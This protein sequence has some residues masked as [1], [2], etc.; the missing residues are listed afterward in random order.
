METPQIDGNQ[1]DQEKSDK[2][3]IGRGFR[4]ALKTPKN[5]PY[6]LELDRNFDCVGLEFDEKRNRLYIG[7]VNQ[8]NKTFV[9]VDPKGLR[10]MVHQDKSGQRLSEWKRYIIPGE[11]SLAKTVDLLTKKYTP[12]KQIFEHYDFSSVKK[13]LT[14]F[15][16]PEPHTTLSDIVSITRNTEKE[17]KLLALKHRK[18]EIAGALLANGLWQKRGFFD[19]KKTA[20]KNFWQIIPVQELIVGDK[21]DLKRW[22]EDA[23]I[24]SAKELPEIINYGLESH[25]NGLESYRNDYAI[26]LKMKRL[27]ENHGHLTEEEY[28]EKKKSYRMRGIVEKNALLKPIRD[29]IK[30]G[31]LPEYPWEI[32]NWDKIPF[33]PLK[34]ALLYG[35]H[36]MPEWEA[37]IKSGAPQIEGLIDALQNGFVADQNIYD[38]E[39]APNIEQKNTFFRPF[40]KEIEDK[41]RKSLVLFTKGKILDGQNV[42]TDRERAI[43][44]K[45]NR[46][47]SLW[48]EK[49]STIGDVKK[50][51]LIDIFEGKRENQ[52]IVPDFACIDGWEWDKNGTSFLA[53]ETIKE[54]KKKYDTELYK[55]NN[56]SDSIENK[57]LLKKYL[58]NLKD[59]EEHNINL[60]KCIAVK[61][62]NGSQK[63]IILENS[64]R[65]KDW[66]AKAYR[67][68]DLND[69]QKLKIF[70]RTLDAIKKE[71][72]PK[73]NTDTITPDI[74][75]EKV[76]KSP[77]SLNSIKESKRM[78]GR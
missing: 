25:R 30:K 49:K 70:C 48:N 44:G 19:K 52:F 56:S 5:F 38:E 72:K 22:W 21:R 24:R 27:Q 17:T 6:H 69:L 18:R 62:E 26:A 47:Y 75:K 4:P 33:E 60:L 55:I 2:K 78:G 15:G 66:K 16:F 7:N 1:E 76:V 68:C 42:L 50:E 58:E 40:K 35:L 59:D 37:Y 36:K 3:I 34:K 14:K 23:L 46:A 53:L 8:V 54:Q 61:H 45:D 9:E 63:E 13:I 43:I 28:S 10:L 29:K 64:S 74:Q 67:N 39:D 73:I 11:L 20:P 77:L 32:R 65:H 57:F 71:L 41:V 12:I 31:S 51:D